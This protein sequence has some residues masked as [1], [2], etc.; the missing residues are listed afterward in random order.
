MYYNPTNS[1]TKGKILLALKIVININYI[2]I[3]T[4]K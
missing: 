3:N 2:N 1:I 4:I